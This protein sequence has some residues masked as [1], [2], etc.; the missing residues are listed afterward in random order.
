[1]AFINY[2]FI[3]EI[4]ITYKG[5]EQKYSNNEFINLACIKNCK[6]ETTCNHQEFVFPWDQMENEGDTWHHAFD[7][8]FQSDSF[9]T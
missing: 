2:L 7:P 1:M 9:Q 4:I 6:N 8:L 3:S 5:S